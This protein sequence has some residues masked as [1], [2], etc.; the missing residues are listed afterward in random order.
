MTNSKL[1][2]QCVE[3]NSSLSKKVNKHSYKVDSFLKKASGNMLITGGTQFE[4]ESLMKKVIAD[5]SN[6]KSTPVFV[7]SSNPAMQNEL[8]ELCNAGEIERLLVSSA[9][10]PSYDFFLGMKKNFIVDFFSQLA[11]IKGYRDTSELNAYVGSFLNILETKSSIN[12]YSI[13]EFSENTDTIISNIARENNMYSDDEIII[14]SSKGGVNFRRL[15]DT[16][17]NAFEHLFCGANKTE[18]NLQSAINTNTVVYIDT[19]SNDFLPLSLYFMN[20]LKQLNSKSFTVVFDDSVIL[21]NSELLDTINILKQRSNINVIIS[22]ES[23]MSLPDENIL[24]NLSRKIVLLNNAQAINDFQLCLNKLFGAYTHFDIT[25]SGGTP[26]HLLYTFLK[27][28]NQGVTQYQRDKV[29]LEEEDGNQAIL[30][31]HNGAEILIVK[32]LVL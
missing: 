20:E 14:S 3:H 21:N 15:I 5:E 16:A 2:N 8:I 6:G 11:L 31:G 22:H 10:Y 12:L 7:F 32:K 13:K 17:M 19:A 18:F 23:I 25:S 4:R 27:S 30:Q 26:P 24:N 1:Q 28:K 29:I 9:D